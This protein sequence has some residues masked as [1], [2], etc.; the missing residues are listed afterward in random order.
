MDIRKL[1]RTALLTHI[2]VLSANLSAQTITL[3]FTTTKV[4]ADTISITQ[5]SGQKVVATH[6]KGTS[7]VSF[8]DGRKTTSTVSC[9]YMTQSEDQ[10]FHVKGLCN[11]DAGKNGS[12]GILTRCNFTN[13]ERTETDCWGKMHGETGSYKGRHGISSWHQKGDISTGTGQWY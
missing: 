11:V 5:S 4:N 3:T 8:S 12:F 6:Y 2:L 7:K 1:W 9:I 10:S 13:K